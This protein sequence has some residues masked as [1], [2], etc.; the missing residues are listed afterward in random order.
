MKDH[1][2]KLAKARDRFFEKNKGILEPS[3]LSGSGMTHYLKNRIE[4]AWLAGAEWG[5][6]NPERTK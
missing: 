5:Q 1:R 2:N 6:A 3:I 4:K